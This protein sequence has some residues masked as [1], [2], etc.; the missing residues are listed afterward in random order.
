MIN[1]KV[2]H[3]YSALTFGMHK[4]SLSMDPCITH[5]ETQL[6]QAEAVTGNLN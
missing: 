4:F 5:A 1:T 6:A 2:E 3:I